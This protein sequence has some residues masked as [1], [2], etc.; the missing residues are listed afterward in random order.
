M[1]NSPYRSMTH[2][3]LSVFRAEGMG[4]FYRSYGTQ[5][6]MNIPFQCAHFVVYEAMQ[7]VSNP[8]RS[9]NPLCH[10]VSGGVSGAVAAAVTTPLD[11]CKT[12]LNTQVPAVTMETGF[13][14]FLFG[15]IEPSRASS[16]MSFNWSQLNGSMAALVLL[17]A[18]Y[19]FNDLFLNPR[20]W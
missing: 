4:A 7:N 10:V 15:T 1:Y 20:S 17:K 13:N 5:L 18:N 2:C 6:V 3:I 19:F 11:V 14:G 16:R 12:L 8:D 9:Y